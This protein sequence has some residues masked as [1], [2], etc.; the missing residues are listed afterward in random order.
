MHC[1]NWTR[2]AHRVIDSR[3]QLSGTVKR[4]TKKNTGFDLTTVWKGHFAQYITFHF[5][6]IQ[7]L[8][9]LDPGQML[10]LSIKSILILQE[11]KMSSFLI[12][13]K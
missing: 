1:Q 8:W 2:A 4:I 3:K 10:P 7:I 9:Y 12:G 6:L 11:G 13:T 5:S